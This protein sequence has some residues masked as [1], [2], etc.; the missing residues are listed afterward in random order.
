MAVSPPSLSLPPSFTPPILT[1]LRP[2][3]AAR[4]P[5]P[6]CRPHPRI[7]PRRKHDVARMLW[8]SRIFPTCRALPC[9]LSFIYPSSN[10]HPPST[11]FPFHT[12]APTL[13]PLYLTTLPPPSTPLSFLSSIYS[14]APHPW[15]P[16][17]DFPSSR[18][19]G[20][21]LL[22]LCSRFSV[23]CARFHFLLHADA[24]PGSALSGLMD[25]RVGWWMEDGGLISGQARLSFVDL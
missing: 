14:D 10:L 3:P 6:F 13:S 21:G 20:R 9:P 18:W 4:R 23:L 25:Q 24:N 11:V 15:F 2:P 19:M 17:L 5:S 7:H 22:F 12:H 8:L 1:L 16:C